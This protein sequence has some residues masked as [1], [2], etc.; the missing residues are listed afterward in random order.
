MTLL[1][2]RFTRAALR[3]I[4]ALRLKLGKHGE[5]LAQVIRSS[6]I[7]P[8]GKYRM[9]TCTLLGDR[10]ARDGVEAVS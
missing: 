6:T 9:N 3:S 2:P 4:P 5:E 1:E 10:T 7:Y 8:V